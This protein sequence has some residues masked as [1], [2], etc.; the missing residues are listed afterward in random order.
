M[1]IEPAIEQ[2]CSY[3]RD[4]VRVIDA[5]AVDQEKAQGTDHETHQIRFYKK[6]ILIT[7][8][9]TLAG[10]RYSKERYPQ[11]NKRNHERFITFLKDHDIWVNGHYVSI[12]FLYEAATSG[13]LSNGRL[14]QFVESRHDSKYDEG[15]FNIDFEDIDVSD[16]EL[17]KLCTTEQEEKTVRE[18]THLELLYRYRNYLVHEARVP[19]NAMEVTNDN[20]P[21][22]HG[23]IGEQKLFLAYPLGHFK[24]IV[25]R[26]IVS[27]EIYLRENQLNPY[28]FVSETARW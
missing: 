11:L 7:Q 17:L 3:F 24:D 13:K 19:G 22:Y 15:S 4:Q 21:Y 28:D 26:S 14:K 20:K 9:D 8:I 5:L 1:S 18:N 2:F 25:E 12:P 6:V 16:H 23:Y 27:I 10:I